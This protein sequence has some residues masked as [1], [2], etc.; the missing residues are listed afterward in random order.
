MPIAPKKKNNK[1]K[2]GPKGKANGDTIKTEDLN[3]D[4]LLENRDGE[5]EAE[6]SEQSPVVRGTPVQLP[7]SRIE[8]QALTISIEHAA[9]WPI[10]GK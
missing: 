10:S 6:D 2:K 3:K 8:A 1:K 7:T 5:G 9:G 4:I